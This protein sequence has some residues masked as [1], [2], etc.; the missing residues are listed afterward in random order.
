MTL[1]VQPMSQSNVKLGDSHVFRSSL[2]ELIAT[3]CLYCHLHI[4]C[5]DC[6]W[7]SC[8]IGIGLR[9]RQQIGGIPCEIRAIAIELDRTNPASQRTSSRWEKSMSW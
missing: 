8:M 6:S 9:I 7:S 1:A 4:G 3:P 2:R 5:F